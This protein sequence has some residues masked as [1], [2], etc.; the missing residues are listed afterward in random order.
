VILLQL[1]DSLKPGN[2][3]GVNFLAIAGI[4]LADLRPEFICT[5]P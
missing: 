2:A 3:R 1:P 5:V 4:I